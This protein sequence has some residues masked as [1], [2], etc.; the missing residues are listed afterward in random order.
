M[1]MKEKNCNKCRVWGGFGFFSVESLCS[2]QVKTIISLFLKRPGKSPGPEFVLRTE[3]SIKELFLSQWDL[4]FHL[5]STDSLLMLIDVR[6]L[7]LLEQ[8]KDTPAE[9]L[10]CSISMFL[11]LPFASQEKKKPIWSMNADEKPRIYCSSTLVGI[12]WKE[13]VPKALVCRAFRHLC[14]LK[15]SLSQSEPGVLPSLQLM[16]PGRAQHQGF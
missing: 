3:V 15:H 7:L 6:E 4:M 13:I 12:Q 11:F 5:K 8:L 14:L 2:L 10:P 16:S 9:K 1:K